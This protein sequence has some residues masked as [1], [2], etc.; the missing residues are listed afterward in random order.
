MQENWKEIVERAIEAQKQITALEKALETK[1]QS[2]LRQR[3][4]KPRPAEYISLYK[5]GLS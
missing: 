1:D 2:S 3:T 4:E 5:F